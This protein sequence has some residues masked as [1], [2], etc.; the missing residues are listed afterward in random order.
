[1]MPIMENAANAAG[2]TSLWVI[3]L[4]LEEF[5]SVGMIVNGVCWGVVVGLGD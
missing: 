4:G 5:V 1:M 3:M 2:Y